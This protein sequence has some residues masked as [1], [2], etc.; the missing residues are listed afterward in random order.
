MDHFVI[1]WG[2]S[3]CLH[4]Q[5]DID[6]SSHRVNEPHA[7]VTIDLIGRPDIEQWE[8]AYRLELNITV[9]E[10]DRPVQLLQ[11]P[12]SYDI[13]LRQIKMVDGHGLD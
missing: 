8:D 6:I 7:E 9:N 12:I 5:K 11:A 4:R 2:H 10:D 1:C 13:I 3:L